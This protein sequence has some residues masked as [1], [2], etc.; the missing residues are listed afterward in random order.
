MLTPF[1]HTPPAGSAATAPPGREPAFAAAG[2][3]VVALG[4]CVG[5]CAPGRGC[6]IEQ[7][8]WEEIVPAVA[9]QAADPLWRAA[10]TQSQ[11]A[12]ACHRDCPAVDVLRALL[13]VTR[14][15]YRAAG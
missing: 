9:A 7:A 13:D 14:P 15:A 10:V 8:V 4:E 2:R 3:Q 12:M 1:A 6:P 11:T 5:T